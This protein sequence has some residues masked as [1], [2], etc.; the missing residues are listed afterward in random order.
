MNLPDIESKWE[1]ANWCVAKDRIL[2]LQY[3]CY[4]LNLGEWIQ[5]Y[6]SFN[7][8][9]S[10]NP[11]EFGRG[12]YGY[13]CHAQIQANLINST[14]FATLYDTLNNPVINFTIFSSNNMQLNATYDYDGIFYYDSDYPMN[15]I[16]FPYDYGQDDRAL[17]VMLSIWKIND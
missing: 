10:V 14:T 9:P 7:F 12:L 11:A 16:T 4:D 1:N 6:T 5:V 8:H 15:Y 17:N 3:A 13:S 2:H